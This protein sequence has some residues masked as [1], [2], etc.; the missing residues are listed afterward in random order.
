MDNHTAGADV[1][2]EQYVTDNTCS[3]IARLDIPITRI[4]MPM[5]PTANSVLTCHLQHIN[6]NT[7]R[8]ITRSNIPLTLLS[9]FMRVMGNPALINQP[10]IK[11]RV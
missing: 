5:P 9:M 4:T 1:V 8:A 6:D 3:V 11:P 2:R 10:A 7:C